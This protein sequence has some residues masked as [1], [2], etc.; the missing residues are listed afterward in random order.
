MNN[1]VSPWNID[2]LTILI[3]ACHFVKKAIFILFYSTRMLQ[4]I[5]ICKI[6]KRISCG[7][8]NLIYI[9]DNNVLFMMLQNARIML[10]ALLTSAAASVIL[11][12]QPLATLAQEDGDLCGEDI[13]GDLE[14]TSDMTCEGDGLRVEGSDLLIHLNGFTIRGPGSDSNTTGILVEEARE[15]RI[16]GPGMVTGFGTGVAYVDAS[17][18][19]MRDIYVRDNDIGV[20]LDATTDTHVKQDH[21][22]DNRIGVINRESNNTEVENIIMGRNNEG[23][24][25]EKSSSVDLDFIILMDG[26]TGIYLDEQSLDNEVFYNVMFRN[27]GTDV[28]FANPGEGRLEN[29]FG[30]NECIQSVP[31]EICTGR[32]EEDASQTQTQPEAGNS[33]SPS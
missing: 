7:V 30:N 5:Q 11:T 9:K 23:I 29:S 22:S 32:I 15:V 31:A 25:L 24:R 3:I 21:V 10:V 2:W 8:T 18:G 14:L 17:G 20:L 1:L 16:R 27:E 33:T 26:G 13:I 4:K 12:V 19:A 6:V 28:T